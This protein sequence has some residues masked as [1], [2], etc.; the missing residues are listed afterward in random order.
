MGAQ[1]PINALIGNVGAEPLVARDTAR[2]AGA[3]N[4]TTWSA[5]E[6]NPPP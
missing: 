6:Y 5:S 1:V 3:K 4:C 2:V